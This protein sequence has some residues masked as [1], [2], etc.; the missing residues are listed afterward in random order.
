MR[1]DQK[2]P[3]PIPLCLLGPL[4][5]MVL[6]WYSY[7]YGN[8]LD[9][10]GLF[11]AFAL[12]ILGWSMAAYLYFWSKK[13]SAQRVY[14][15]LYPNRIETGNGEVFHACFSSTDHLIAD[16]TKLND[17]VAAVATRK[18]H[19]GG[20]FIFS[21]ESAHVRIW[22]QG[23]GIGELELNAIRNAFERE[24]IDPAF[25]IADGNQPNKEI[26]IKA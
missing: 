22:P 2:L 26:G 13:L 10:W 17:C 12:P 14:L 16:S 6:A 23:K 18:S 8:G 15:G 1:T 21:R 9:S 25:E 3:N 5:L 24:F 20:R 19:S 7:V 11:L 4:P